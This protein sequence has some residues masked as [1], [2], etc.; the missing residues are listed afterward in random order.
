[1]AIEPQGIESMKVGNRRLVWWACLTAVGLL[2]ML[3]SVGMSWRQPP[4]P[5]LHD[6]FSNL[7]VADTLRHAR[8]ANPPPE[9]WQ[10]FQSFHVLVNP[11]YASKYP[12]GP[13]AL[14]ALGW[15][16]WGSPVAGIWLGA[17]LC[18]TAVT[19]AAAGCFP[20]RWALFAGVLLALNP[21]VHHQ[22]SL[23][24]MNGWLTAACSALVAGGVLRL[25]KRFRWLDAV[26]LGVGIGGLALTRP[27]EGLLFTVSSF[28][29]LMYW[30]R[31]Q[32]WGDKVRRAFHIVLY[33]G[34]PVAASLT[35]IVFHNLATTGQAT[36]MPYQLHETLYGVAPLSIFQSERVPEMTQWSADVPPTVL[37]FHYG[38]SLDS[39]HQRN[40]LKGWC[41]AIA[42]RLHVVSQFWGWSFCMVCIMMIVR[43]RS[44]YRPLA[45][46]VG[47][48]LLIGSFV[49]WY[50]SHYFAPSLVWLVILTTAGAYWLMKRL[51]SDR[52]AFRLAICVILIMQAIFL[53]AELAIANSRPRSWADQRQELVEQLPRDGS[54]HLILVRYHSQHNVHDE[55]VYNGADLDN[56]PVVWARSWRPD[57]DAELLNRYR[58]RHVWLLELDERDQATLSPVPSGMN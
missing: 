53:S 21:S 49:P 50:F 2:A 44:P 30:W 56:A 37:A 47:L 24:Y 23:S 7:L 42:E 46:T 10:P 1:M 55:W 54:R 57:L 29:L 41:A 22:W 4:A 9:I 27:F 48:A 18:A 6:E 43:W 40:H 17:G 26:A 32:S 51:A 16:L 20:R 25:R 3:V 13:G 35:L 38:W 14:L 39:Y 45:A 31:H 34:A 28:G 11:S 33:T 36:R 5:S 8:L 12:L 52:F 19:W 58:D 15:W